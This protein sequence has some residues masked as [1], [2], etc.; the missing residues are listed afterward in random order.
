MD[1]SNYI[2]K[3]RTSWNAKTEVHIHSAF[4]NNDN[5]LRGRNTLNNIELNLLGDITGK[6]ILH[7][8]CHFGQDTISLARL[9]ANVTGVDFSD[10]AISHAI[11]FADQTNV[12]AEFICCNVY[13]LPKYTSRKFDVVFT[14]YGTIGWLPDLDEWARLISEY[15]EP[16]GIFVFAEFHPVVWMFDD[17]FTKIVYNYF[18]DEAIEE[19]LSGTYADKDAPIEYETVSWNHSISEVLNSLIKNGLEINSFDEFDYSPYNC[20]NEMEEFEE[21]KFRIKHFGNK[22]PLVYSLLATKKKQ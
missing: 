15:L 14:S 18:I 8:Q 6:S 19:T 3:N 2:D 10:K 4:Y 9:G 21:N 12:K 22:I 7:L 11:N 20:F 13:D 16:G 5:F 17:N 1:N